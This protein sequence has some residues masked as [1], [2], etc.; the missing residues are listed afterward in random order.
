ML[1]KTDAEKAFGVETY[2]SPEMDAAI[3]LW[4][5]LESGKPPWVKD[6][7]GRTVAFWNTIAEEWAK[8]IAQNIDIKVQGIRS[9]EMPEKMQEIIDKY[10]LKNARDNIH[11]MVFW[12]GI[13]AK[14]DG[15]GIEFLKPN[16]FLPTEY[17]SSGEIKAAIFFSYYQAS[18]K[19]YTKAE[20]HRF[21]TETKDGVSTRIYHVS[22]KAFRSDNQ[23]DIGR[24]V[25]LS[26]TKW[27][28][29]EPEFWAENLEKPLFRYIKCPVYNFIDSD[30]PLGVPCFANCTEELRWL[31]I[32]MSTM[33]T[34]TENSTPMMMVDQSVIQYATMNGIQL[35]KFIMN[36]G[37]DLS[38]D[39]SKPV[40]QWQ[41][42]LQVTSRKEGINFYLSVIGYKCGFDPGYFVFDGQNIQATTA[43]Q[44]RV[45]QKRT[46]D[47]ALSYRDVLDKPNT[48]GDGRVGAIHDIA[49]IINAMLVI[50]GDVPLTDNGNY[51]LFCSFA[52]L[53]KNEE[54]DAAMDLQLANQGFMA[55]FRWLV[56]HRGYTED[57]ARKMV[58]EAMKESRANG[59][60][61]RLFGEE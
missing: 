35:P 3:K 59:Q 24:E 18:K 49:Y 29:I 27:K 13:M 54:E 60:D 42:Q 32:A 34:E 20:W 23:D 46:A 61:E 16:M 31:D 2:L 14:W 22:T 11:A 4:G 48:N 15:E 5:Q 56:L 10:F 25:Q 30:S 19:F 37:I 12:G 1:F 33:G 26:E 38:G 51:E 36:T 45:T 58:Q 50:N 21:E 40:E 52:D 44:V 6:G 17:D 43:T 9:G 53:L 28:D 41:P 39:G 55:K 57:E 8:L 47:T 7:D